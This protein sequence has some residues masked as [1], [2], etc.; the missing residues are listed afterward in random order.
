MFSHLYAINVFFSI[1]ELFKNL[2][3]LLLL[4]LLFF[5]T[6]SYKL[7]AHASSSSPSSRTNRYIFSPFIYLSTSK[8]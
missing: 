4:L 8:G 2:T 5:Q 6:F 1:F 3:L 7:V